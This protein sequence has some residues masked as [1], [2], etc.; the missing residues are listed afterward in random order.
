VSRA[1]RLAAGGGA[2][3]LHIHGY[4][5]ALEGRCGARTAPNRQNCADQTADRLDDDD[6]LVAELA[7]Q[8]GRDVEAEE[9]A[10][11]WQD[12]GERGDD[13]APDRHRLAPPLGV[14]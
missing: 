5:L 11:G 4:L 1:A 6:D 2:G 12:G 9:R 7:D 14:G 13:D 3:T 8:L 10:E